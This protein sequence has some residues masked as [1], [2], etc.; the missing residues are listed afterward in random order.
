MGFV[1]FPRTLHKPPQSSLGSSTAVLMLSTST[2]PFPGGKKQS[3]G[4]ATVAIASLK[5]PLSSDR[6]SDKNFAIEHLFARKLLKKQ[7]D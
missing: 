4:K 3:C 5:E 2:S 7:M 6:I 1:Y